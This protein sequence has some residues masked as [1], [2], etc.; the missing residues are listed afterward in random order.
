M[1]EAIKIYQPAK[2]KT[3]R[4]SVEPQRRMLDKELAKKSKW[5]WRREAM[6]QAI[7]EHEKQISYM[8]FRHPWFNVVY[9]YIIAAM[10]VILFAAFCAWGVQIK[11]DRKAETLTATAMA[12]YQAE[13]KAIE[14]AKNAELAAIAASEETIMKEEA[15]WCARIIYGVKNFIDKYH[16][17]EEDLYTL[18]R[19]VFNR[20]ENQTNGFQG[21]NTVEEIAN[22]E[23]S[24]W[25]GY[26]SSNPVLSEYYKVAYA[27]VE[28]WHHESY[29]PISNDFLWAELT[30]NGIWLRNVYN[31]DGYARRW[32]YSK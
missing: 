27:A 2:K 31:A 1:D 6:T 24:Q 17:S 21:L 7:N 16:Y 12:D 23:G 29:K 30:A 3:T 11:I 15:E 13:Q 8:N 28:E 25:T 9:N 10:V 5:K 14:D 18:L 26:K 22:Q 20:V 32:R 4:V 19:C